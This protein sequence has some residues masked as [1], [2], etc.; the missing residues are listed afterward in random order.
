MTLI[1]TT[2]LYQI[3]AKERI[4]FYTCKIT[5]IIKRKEDDEPIN[6]RNK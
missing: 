4:N 1:T 3:L 5:L 2:I 6:R